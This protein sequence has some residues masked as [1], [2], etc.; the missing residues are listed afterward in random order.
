MRIK[1]NVLFVVVKSRD[2]C[3]K[4][5]LTVRARTLVG[6]SMSELS[7]IDNYSMEIFKLRFR[8]KGRA[9]STNR[10]L[11]PITLPTRWSAETNMQHDTASD[12]C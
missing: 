8:R 10:E 12:T 5:E 4:Y 2:A 9:D 1:T 11:L 7:I 6:A 3:F